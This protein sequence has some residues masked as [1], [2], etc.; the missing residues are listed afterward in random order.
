MTSERC[1]VRIFFWPTKFYLNN[2][3]SCPHDLWVNSTLGLWPHGLWLIW[4]WRIIIVNYSSITII[5]I[6]IIVMLGFNCTM[7]GH[8]E[9]KQGITCNLHHSSKWQHTKPDWRP[10]L[11]PSNASYQSIKLRS[12]DI[13]MGLI[14]TWLFIRTARSKMK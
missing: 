7:E 14:K 13:I 3:S 5:I 9:I 11:F 10:C 6:V 1:S 12:N 8:W 4:A 2:Y